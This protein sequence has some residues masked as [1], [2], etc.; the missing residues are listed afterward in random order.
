[1]HMIG[2]LSLRECLVATI[3]TL[4]LGLIISPSKNWM[5]NNQQEVYIL[6]QMEVF[7]TEETAHNDFQ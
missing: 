5:M 6:Q 2:I 4:E 7:V 3:P 1:M